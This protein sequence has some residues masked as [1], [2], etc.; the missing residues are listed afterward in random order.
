M[1][2]VCT[3]A[4]STSLFHYM[5][6]HGV[7]PLDEEDLVPQRWRLCTLIFFPCTNISLSVT[8]SAYCDLLGQ[9]IWILV[10][11]LCSTRLGGFC[12]GAKQHTSKT[13]YRKVL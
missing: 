9:G 4:L 2:S 12:Q 10:S 13:C 11:V 6:Y 8:E 1:S 3:F 7:Q 5:F